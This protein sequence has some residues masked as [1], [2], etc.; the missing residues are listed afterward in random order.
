MC[1]KTIENT[2]EFFLIGYRGAEHDLTLMTQQTAGNAFLVWRQHT[3]QEVD[4]FTHPMLDF[5]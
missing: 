2:A 1:K 4:I 5:I 3:A